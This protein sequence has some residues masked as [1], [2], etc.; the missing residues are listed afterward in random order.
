MYYA[1]WEYPYSYQRYVY[2]ENVPMYNNYIR[3]HHYW[4]IYDNG[5]NMVKDYGRQPYVVNINEA[6]KHNNTYRTTLWTGNHLQVTLMSINVGEDIG[7]EIHP[8]VDQFL[9][10]EQGQGVVQ[11]GKRKDQLNFIQQVFDD[12]AIMIPA[13]TWHN[14]TNTGNTPLK[15][16][17]I[18]APP[19][20]PAGT[21]HLT[22]AQAMA[23]E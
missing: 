11:M 10:I 4:N 19:Q 2:C 21:V 13:G 1:P 14:V 17:S 9:R 22:K 7:L 6:A 23:T 12:Y 5:R 18:Y 3:Q 8:N 16:Y 15:L 20:H